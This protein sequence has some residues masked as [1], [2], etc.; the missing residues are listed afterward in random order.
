MNERTGL[1]SIFHRREGKAKLQTFLIL[2]VVGLIAS[3]LLGFYTELAYFVPEK[4]SWGFFSFC[5]I[6][7]VESAGFVLISSVS[8]L[9]RNLENR[10]YKWNRFLICYLAVGSLLV[11]LNY[12]LFV[13]IKWLGGV[14]EPY[15][16]RAEGLR[17]LGL[18]WL[19]EMLVLGQMFMYKY[20]SFV[21]QSN[22]ERQLLK[23]ENQRTRYQALQSQLNPHFLFNS[24]NTLVAEI[25]FNPDNAVT[26]T[27]ELS[28]VY[29]YVLANQQ[30]D[31]VPLKDEVDFMHSYL[32]VQ[33]VR[34]GSCLLLEEMI[35]EDC[36]GKRLPPL[37]LQIL[38]ENVLKHNQIDDTCPM[39]IS[40][41]VSASGND[42]FLCLSNPVHPRLV[43]V[44]G[45]KK[46]LRNLNARYMLLC[47]KPVE[48][49]SRKD[50]FSVKIPLLND[51]R[52]RSLD[53]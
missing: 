53:C 18:V 23:E 35:P 16:V 29:R 3:L 51:R 50:F 27:R 12:I 49:I 28:E 47:R 26:F 6:L 30:S 46:G 40:L 20:V 44:K 41:S 9:T 33:R 7:I 52:D 4:F 14:S 37:A 5:S 15:V 36:L 39:K 25:S 24:L 34:L 32:F 48:I 10:F 43:G 21:E 42:Y 1:R 22:K 2:G 13:G 38:V 19:L 11:L 31:T 17:M 45:E 8:Y